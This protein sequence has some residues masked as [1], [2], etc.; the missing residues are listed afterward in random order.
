[1]KLM[2][3]LKSSFW[4]S[5]A[6]VFI[7]SRIV[8]ASDPQLQ[9]LL[10]PGLAESQL[11]HINQGGDAVGIC[12]LYDAKGNSIADFACA[13]SKGN[14]TP[15]PKL[16]HYRKMEC[17]A[18]SDSGMI[19]GHAYSPEREEDSVLQAIVFNPHSAINTTLPHLPGAMAT[20]ATSIS[21][22]GKTIVGVC[23]GHACVWDLK[24][25][26]WT[27]SALPQKFDGLSTQKVCLSD[28]GRIAVAFQRSSQIAQLAQWS[29]DE[30]GDWQYTV[31][32]EKEIA[33]HD[34]NNAATI[35][36]SKEVNSVRRSE[37]RGFVLSPGKEIELIEPFDG[38]NFS[39]ARSVNNLGV[40]VGWSDGVGDESKWP[41]SLVWN[42]GQLQPLEIQP[43]T[44]PSQAFGVNDNSEVV[45]LLERENDSHAVGFVTKINT[46]R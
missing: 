46:L 12:E 18:L 8:S 13:F 5:V 39:T 43:S 25:G 40:V 1:M 16:T 35:V 24:K 30:K 45:G 26:S 38:D 10:P 14:V 31:R 41:R 15:I 34:V 7:W 29:R 17:I 42:N 21:G 32:L 28:N 11:W 22:D 19:V 37:T 44:T 2:G 36:G 6:F 33:P 3:L 20:L 4:P 9:L 27:V 23:S